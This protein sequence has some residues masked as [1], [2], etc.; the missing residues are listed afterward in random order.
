MVGPCR[1]GAEYHAGELEVILSLAPTDTNVANL[2]LLLDR[3]E[4]AVRIVYRIAYGKL[5]PGG[6]KDKTQW[7]KIR[8]AMTSIGLRPL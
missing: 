7:R 2:A 1:K 4:E 6:D 3:S 5:V 8:K